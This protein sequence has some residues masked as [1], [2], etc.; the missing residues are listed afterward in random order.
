[1]LREEEKEKKGRNNP[2]SHKFNICV[3]WMGR[4]TDAPTDGPIDG[5]LKTPSYRD[6]RMH[7]K[8]RKAEENK[9][10][11]GRDAEILRFVLPHNKTPWGT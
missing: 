5:K 8:R 7:L 2:I 4:W 9:D 3:R 1:M 11:Q 10:L 6:S